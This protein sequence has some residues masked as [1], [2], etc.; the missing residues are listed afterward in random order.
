MIQEITRCRTQLLLKNPFFGTL[1]LKLKITTNPSVDTMA[2]DG[3]HLFYDENFTKTLS[4]DELQGVICHEILHCAFKHM[5]RKGDRESHKWN[6]ACDY[7]INALLL[8][9]FHMKLPQDR[10]YKPEYSKL[11]AEEI[12]NRLPDNPDW[13]GQ[14]WGDFLDPTEEG[15]TFGE[16]E[17][18]WAIAMK[19]ALEAAKA[20]G[21]HVGQLAE[22]IK[23]TEAK[24]NWREQ[25]NRIIGAHA[26]TDFTWLR[27]DPAY[28]HK[29]FIIPTLHEPS[30]G[31]LTFA[32]DTSGS[33]SNNELGR[34]VGELQH[35]LENVHF[36]GITV[37]QCDCQINRVDEYERDDQ[38]P[39]E[40]YGRG[41]TR[42]SPVFDYIKDHPTDGLIY[43]TDMEPC[44]RWPE[45]PGIPVF[46]ART[47]SKSA[48]FG[49]HI[50]VYTAA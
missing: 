24:I 13:N 18:E 40:V 4:E 47:T 29:N 41:G 21:Q 33:V 27:P 19:S 8:E 46:W 26:K 35:V 44:E 2:T 11:S 39:T 22:L 6:I 5:Y 12:Y 42:F 32:I 3:Y 28:L 14:G 48:P 7:A 16:Q 45:D 17:A 25:L 23:A 36:D 38:L 1:A 50:D 49:E 9:D 20:A 10:L 34:F 30:I 31:H 15:G 37:I 43:F